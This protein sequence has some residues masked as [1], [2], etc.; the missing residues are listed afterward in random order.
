M[1]CGGFMFLQWLD[2][3]DLI[4]FYNILLDLIDGLGGT[5]VLFYCRG[6]WK[7][8]LRIILDC[9]AGHICLP[10]AAQSTA[11]PHFPSIR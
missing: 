8:L 6:I 9:L 5:L 3:Q 7:N 11:A 10:A 2:S 4:V 1:A